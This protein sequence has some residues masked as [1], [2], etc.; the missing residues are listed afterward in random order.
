[1]DSRDFQKEYETLAQYV[2]RQVRN[3]R[4]VYYKNSDGKAIELK[5]QDK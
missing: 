3:G 1:M 4:P 5:S 2:M